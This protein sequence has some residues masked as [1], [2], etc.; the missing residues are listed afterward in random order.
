[1]SE[2]LFPGLPQSRPQE[3]GDPLRNSFAITPDDDTDLTILTRAIYV[4]VG[5]NVTA[6]LAD[7]VAEVEFV[8]VAAGDILPL[9][10]KR[11]MATGTTATD[12]VGLY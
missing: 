5:G 4:G 3:R 12:I 8:G 6:R 1:M 7:D 2:D 10:V 11:L 9:R